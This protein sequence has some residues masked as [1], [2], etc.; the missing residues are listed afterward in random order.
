MVKQELKATIAR[1]GERQGDLAKAIGIFP[2]A[3]SQK[4]NGKRK[5]TYPEMKKII[6]HYKL[7]S[8]EI[9]KIF[10]ADVVN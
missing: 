4:I 10:F 9:I 6:I 1:H 7:S 5:F 3:L 2:S 8:D